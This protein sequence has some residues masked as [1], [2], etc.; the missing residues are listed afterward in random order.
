MELRIAEKNGTK[1]AEV[2][3]DKVELRTV[4]DALDLMVNADYKGARCLALHK[5]NIDPDFFDLSTRLAGDILQKCATY[6]VKFVILG[7]FEK[8]ASESLKAFIIECNRGNGIFFVPN[9]HDAFE[10]MTKS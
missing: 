6:Q 3:S 1:I 10:L 7:E 4:Q 2:V 8:D 9:V 5:D